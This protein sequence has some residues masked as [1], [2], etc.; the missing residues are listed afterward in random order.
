MYR[1]WYRYL[2]R[3]RVF[4]KKFPKPIRFASIQNEEG[5]NCAAK[6]LHRS[7]DLKSPSPTAFSLLTTGILIGQHTV[8]W[9]TLTNRKPPSPYYQQCEE[10]KPC[11]ISNPWT[12]KSASLLFGSRP[13]GRGSSGW[14]ER[15]RNK[16]HGRGRSPSRRCPQLEEPVMQGPFLL[17]SYVNSGIKIT[18]TSPASY[19]KCTGNHM[20]FGQESH[21]IPIQIA[22][23][24]ICTHSFSMDANYRYSVSASTWPKVFVDLKKKKKKGIG[25]SL[26]ESELKAALKVR[27][28]LGGGDK[29]H[30]SAQA[31]LPLTVIIL[32]QNLFKKFD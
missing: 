27:E 20:W 8:I 3:R 6:W 31:S 12:G 32:L 11:G 21:H 10:R 17:R 30:I 28:L 16:S 22:C 26:I 24:A 2:R 4:V 18:M 5:T 14:L 19:R 13:G 7:G 29:T 1:S 23:S 15:R 9:M 25:A